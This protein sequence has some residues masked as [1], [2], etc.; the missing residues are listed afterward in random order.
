MKIQANF[1]FKPHHFG[2]AIRNLQTR[3]FSNQLN[4]APGEAGES[5]SISLLKNPSKTNATFAC[6]AIFLNKI[7]ANR[8]VYSRYF[9]HFCARSRQFV[10]N[11]LCVAFSTFVCGDFRTWQSLKT[12]AN[13]E[14]DFPLYLASMELPYQTNPT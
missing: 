10:T 14:S 4:V 11:F 9:E 6:L 1:D 3:F 8:A 7:Q 2:F 12:K 13:S 5:I